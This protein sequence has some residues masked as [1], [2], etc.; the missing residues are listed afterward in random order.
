MY[1]C[2]FYI[3]SNKY[4]KLARYLKAFSLRRRVSYRLLH[5]NYLKNQPRT[6]V[7]LFLSEQGQCIINLYFESASITFG[8]AAMT[9]N[10]PD[11]NIP[12]LRPK[13]YDPYFNLPL[14]EILHIFDPASSQTETAVSRS[15]NQATNSCCTAAE[16][17]VEDRKCGI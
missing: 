3:C 10:H 8:R 12:E 1:T 5:T 11:L 6:H 14:L 17:K 16:V 15:S 13:M 9:I 4:Q 2:I 7:A